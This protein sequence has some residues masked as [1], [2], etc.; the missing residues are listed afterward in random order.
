MRC[1]SCDEDVSARDMRFL[2]QGELL[3]YCQLALREEIE[4]RESAISVLEVGK[5]E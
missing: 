2:D 3:Q 1:V 4:F 5:G